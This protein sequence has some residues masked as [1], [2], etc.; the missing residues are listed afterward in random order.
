ME[1]T[2]I[3]GKNVPRIDAVEKVTG[4]AKYVADYKTKGMLHAKILGSP[5]PHAKI[6][7]IDTSKAQ[8][9]AGVRAVIT[10]KDVPSVSIDP[11]LGDQFMLPLDNIVRYAG[12]PVAA[13]AAESIEVAE[14]AIKLTV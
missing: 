2:E 11:N 1:D 3:I 5:F 14:E 12:D 13:I 10:P 8:S 6:I 7:S 4:K 9:L